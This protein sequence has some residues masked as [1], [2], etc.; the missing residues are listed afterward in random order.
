MKP[1]LPS[2]F[3][4]TD[5]S[6]CVEQRYIITVLEK[7]FTQHGFLPLATP[8]MEH[9]TTL[10]GKYGDEG[11][12]LLFKVLNSGDFLKHV[13]P[14]ELGAQSKETTQ[15]VSKKGLRYDL[16]VPLARYVA[17]HRHMLTFPFKRYQIQP[18]WRAE[19]PQQNRYR[20][21]YQC[22][23]DVV[24]GGS[25]F[26]EASLLVI[27]YEALQALNLRD[28]TIHLNHRLL[29]T[30]I[31]EDVGMQGQEHLFC[32]A[33]DKKDKIGEQQ[34]LALL[35]EE[36]LASSSIDTLK[37]LFISLKDPIKQLNR[38]KVACA[39]I[40]KAMQALEE[41]ASMLTYIQHLNKDLYNVLNIDA[42]LARGLSYYTG[43]IFEI[44]PTPST[45]GSIVGGGRYDDLTAVFGLDN[46]SGV[47]L[48][49][50]LE[51]IHALMKQQG[52]FPEHLGTTLQVL[53]APMDAS[54]EGMT[55]HYLVSLRKKNV[56]AAFYPP[57]K[58]IKKAFAYAHAQK[59]P[60]VA[61]VGS[62]EA[63]SN[64]LT[65]KNMHTGQ[66]KKCTFAEMFSL[67]EHSQPT[68]NIA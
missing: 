15:K 23:I 24:G 16:T 6:A 43:A 13:T 54:T 60:W 1:S 61:V 49:F 63:A 38:L 21:F 7:I 22:D 62:Q 42:T 19:R 29:L 28:F 35:S 55:L 26:Y 25:L 47:G 12:A 56:P 48:S 57:R 27:A 67:L 18:V 32:Q 66:Q 51:R 50:G 68:P 34:V 36:G 33:L 59:I 20:E 64:T 17:Q 10:L 4:D 52:A 39:T 40:P 2:G 14:K 8:A 31:A 65:L 44:K 3:R 37:T 45:L 41:M 11:E 30:A 9:L 46:V 58:A 53:L 5:P